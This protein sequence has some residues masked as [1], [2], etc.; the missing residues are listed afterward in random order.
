MF[1]DIVYI[2]IKKSQ[3]CYSCNYKCFCE[4]IPRP[5]ARAP[6][7][8]Q[9]IFRKAILFVSYEFYDA[10]LLIF[11]LNFKTQIKCVYQMKNKYTTN[12]R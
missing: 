9:A 4:I 10:I 11:S 6:K 12:I 8:N 3:E 5:E 1:A 7:P 2:G